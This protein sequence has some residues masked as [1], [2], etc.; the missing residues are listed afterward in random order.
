[1][2]A[3]QLERAAGEVGPLDAGADDLV[4]LGRL[5]GELVGERERLDDG[6]ERVQ[7]VLAR[8]AD[9][10]AEVDLGGRSCVERHRA[11]P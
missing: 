10:E 2:L 3:E 7:P 11:P 8:R 9:E 6:D 1:V 5:E 4:A